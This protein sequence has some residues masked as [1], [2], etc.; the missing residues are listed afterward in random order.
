MQ[1]FNMTQMVMEANPGSELIWSET[2]PYPQTIL[3]RS[4]RVRYQHLEKLGPRQPAGEVS[5]GGRKV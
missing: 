3:E 5:E 4:K 2:N 1:K